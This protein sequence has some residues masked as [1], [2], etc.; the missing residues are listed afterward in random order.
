MLPYLIDLRNLGPN[1]RVFKGEDEVNI[2]LIDKE[3][4]PE[5]MM[6]IPYSFANTSNYISVSENKYILLQNWI[7]GE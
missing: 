6:Y 5:D 7:R 2:T 4:H 1:V 3:G